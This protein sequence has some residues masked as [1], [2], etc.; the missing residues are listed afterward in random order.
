[1]RKL[2]RALIWIIGLAVLLVGGVAVAYVIAPLPVF[3]ALMIKDPGAKLI[4]RNITY[5]ENPRQRYNLFS[6]EEGKDF[7]LLI[8]VQGGAWQFADKEGYD[9]V[10]HAFASKGYLTAVIDYRLVPEVQYPAFV[11][12][13]AKAVAHMRAEAERHG[14]DPSRV[15]LVGHSAGAYNIIQAMLNPAFAADMQNIR[16]AAAMAGPYKFVPLTD[17]RAIKAFSNFSPID[18]TQ[19]ENFLKPNQPPILLVHGADDTEV[20]PASSEYFYGEIKKVTERAEL[21]I[22]PDTNHVSILGDLSRPFRYR[23]ET[24]PDIIAFFAKH[25]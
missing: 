10:G 9:F 20:L 4:A 12:D 18:E 22:Y 8:F 15:Y 21:H 11:E 23:S 3:N 16:A 25:H 1:M 13:T 7:P 5:G 14:G 6:P 19:P 17:P 2:I 24:F